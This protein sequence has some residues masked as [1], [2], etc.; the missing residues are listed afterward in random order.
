[1]K[2]SKKSKPI[3]FSNTFSIKSPMCLKTKSLSKPKQHG[4]ASKN[5]PELIVFIVLMN[6]FSSSS[7]L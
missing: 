5:V 6:I 3:K 1:M 4:N 7:S 2:T